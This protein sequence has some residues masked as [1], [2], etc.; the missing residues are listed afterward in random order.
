MA[1]VVFVGPKG[2]SAWQFA[3]I[4][5]V[6]QATCLND[7]FEVKDAQG[8]NASLI[9]ALQSVAAHTVTL[10]GSPTLVVPLPW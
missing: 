8:T 5:G 2:P 6:R 7:Q 3:T 9:A 10:S 4:K 1:I